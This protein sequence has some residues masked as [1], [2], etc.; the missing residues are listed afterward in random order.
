MDES[1][2]YEYMESNTELTDIAFLPFDEEAAITIVSDSTGSVLFYDPVDCKWSINFQVN[3]NSDPI[4]AIYLTK[5]KHLI[6][7]STK[8]SIWKID[9]DSD[10][11]LPSPVLLQS[12]QFANASNFRPDLISFDTS[13]STLSLA[14]SSQSLLVFIA[15]FS[16]GFLVRTFET[17][18]EILSI[19]CISNQ[20]EIQVLSRQPDFIR[21]F[22]YDPNRISYPSP[23]VHQEPEA[24]SP[25]NIALNNRFLPASLASPSTGHFTP[26]IPI[27]NPNV[28]HSPQPMSPYQQL[29]IQSGPGLSLSADSA[30]QFH[31]GFLPGQPAI[32]NQNFN[33]QQSRQ[34]P[35]QQNFAPHLNMSPAAVQSPP[36]PHSL[37]FSVQNQMPP[38]FSY[39]QYPNQPNNSF[40]YPLMPNRQFN[41]PFPYPVSDSPN[42]SEMAGASILNQLNTSNGASVPSSDS[43]STPQP[44]KRI[45]SPAELFSLT[46]PQAPASINPSPSQ[47]TSLSDIEND[48]VPEADSTPH[49]S[50]IQS[51]EPQESPQSPQNILLNPKLFAQQSENTAAEDPDASSTPET[52]SPQNE[53]AENDESEGDQQLSVEQLA[54]QQMFSE[55]LDKLIDCLGALQPP[56]FN[57][58]EIED[59]IHQRIA[60]SVDLNNLIYKVTNEK[61]QKLVDSVR[62]TVRSDINA[63]AREHIKNDIRSIFESQI[64]PAFSKSCNIMLS[65]INTSFTKCLEEQFAELEDATALVVPVDDD[66]TMSTL[67]ST[68]ETLGKT[69]ELLATRHFV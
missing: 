55:K 67:N 58:K 52:E 61:T 64:N 48:F 41:Y 66:V 56:S 50:P 57:E 29:P 34:L 20:S 19:S 6:T 8:I 23:Q 45:I 42:F 54:A 60:K 28:L 10:N 39:P 37:P 1:S 30:Q 35:M 33:F 40:P 44:T 68:C 13:S 17:L 12:F 46:N 24:S 21:K 47:I 32:P 27:N 22:H 9:V 31:Q 3:E 14:D 69:I 63:V 18:H 65:K 53:S 36:M 25:F 5:D 4:K 7:V 38:N 26:P 62:H 15:F 51:N 11:S 16:S 43:P 2:G 59:L 49:K